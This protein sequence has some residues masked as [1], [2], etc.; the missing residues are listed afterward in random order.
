MKQQ[1]IITA[2]A[3]CLAATT[4]QA[5]AAL[6]EVTV[7]G[8]VTA[9]QTGVSQICRAQGFNV[10][11]YFPLND[12][13]TMSFIYDDASAL[14]YV[15]NGTAAYY[16]NAIKSISFS[17]TFVNY[18]GTYEGD[19]GQIIVRDS[20]NDGLTFRFY[21][22][23]QNSYDYATGDA[24]DLT[25]LQTEVAHAAD[26]VYGDLEINAIR[27]NLTSNS[28]S[29]FDSLDIPVSF[30]LADFDNINSTNWGFTVR[31]ASGF[32]GSVGLSLDTISIQAVSNVPV[33]AAVWLFGSGLV[34]LVGIARR[35]SVQQLK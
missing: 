21:E 31:T 29:L 25:T 23:T 15:Q 18:N 24:M 14:S 7:T 19:F 11:Q 12:A 34:A 28:S 3:L 2:V 4:F 26:D 16:D 33:P 27:I 6:Y 9:N 10:C 20:T 1:S 35:K 13:V 8:Q 22:S 5:N 30:D 17:S 32:G